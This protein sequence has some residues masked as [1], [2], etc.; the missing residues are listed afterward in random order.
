MINYKS[1]YKNPNDIVPYWVIKVDEI[2]DYAKREASMNF[3]QPADKY[4][5]SKGEGL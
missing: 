5:R 2:I 4:R 1:N 3:C